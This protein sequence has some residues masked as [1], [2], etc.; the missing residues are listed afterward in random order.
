MAVNSRSAIA[1]AAT[2]ALLAIS[3]CGRQA[4]EPQNEVVTSRSNGQA[5]PDPRRGSFEKS[6][7]GTYGYTTPPANAAATKP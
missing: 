1:A 4:T 2:L 5:I 6:E 7:P 3:A